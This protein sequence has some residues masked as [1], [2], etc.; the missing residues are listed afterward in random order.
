MA[1]VGARE[2]AFTLLTEMLEPPHIISINFVV[3]EPAFA[4]YK[5]D[6]RIQ[7]WMAEHRVRVAADQ[8]QYEK[9]AAQ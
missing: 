3:S 6:P 9:E 5:D 4:N 1:I 2:E 8:A 7:A